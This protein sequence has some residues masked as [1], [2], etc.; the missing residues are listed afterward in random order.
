MSEVTHT[1]AQVRYVGDLAIDRQL[2]RCLACWRSFEMRQPQGAR[3]YEQSANAERRHA[4]PWRR[5][6][7][8][9]EAR[10]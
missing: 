4:C 1:L 8:G 9:I 5:T 7:T 3:W 6:A 2:W 10:R